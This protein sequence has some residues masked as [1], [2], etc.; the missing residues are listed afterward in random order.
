[1]AQEPFILYRSNQ[2]QLPIAFEYPSA[3]QPEFSKGSVEPYV[4]VQVYGP[5]SLESRLRTY[6]AVRSMPNAAEGGK[7]GDVQALVES[8][9]QHLMPSFKIDKDQTTQ[10]LGIPARM[11]DISGTLALPWEAKDPQAIPIRGQR[12]FFE[13]NKRLYELSWLATPETSSIVEAAFQ[14]LLATLSLVE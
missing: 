4:Q 8:Y 9:L 14:K 7:Y 6:I 5:A 11:L 10:V 2:P 12:I 1:M 3:W 13:K